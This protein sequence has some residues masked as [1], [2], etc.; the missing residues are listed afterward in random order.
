MSET[1]TIELINKLRTARQRG[2]WSSM[3]QWCEQSAD[4]IESQAAQIE[5]LRND[6]PER[7]RFAAT[8]ELIRQ[9]QKTASQVKRLIDDALKGEGE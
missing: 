8:N 2:S 4:L 3:L 5:R 1:A 9:A 6:R 7:S